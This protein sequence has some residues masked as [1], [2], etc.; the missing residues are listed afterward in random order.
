MK[1]SQAGA[2]A[3]SDGSKSAEDE[4]SAIRHLPGSEQRTS[5][6]IGGESRVEGTIGVQP[7]YLLPSHIC[8]GAEVV[9]SQQDAAVGLKADSVE[10]KV[11]QNNVEARV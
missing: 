6:L 8:A 4:D 11:V 10:T 5:E 2:G 1:E 9:P 3:A 7:D